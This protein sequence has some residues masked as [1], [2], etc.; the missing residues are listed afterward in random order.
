MPVTFIQ[1]TRFDVAFSPTSIS[2][3]RAWYDAA[4]TA[5]ITSTGGYVTQWNDKSS[6]AYHATAAG[7]DRPQTGIN[8]INGR[9]VLT[10]DTNKLTIPTAFTFG[11]GQ[12]MTTYAVVMKNAVTN[13]TCILN[14]SDGVGPFFALTA[15]ATSGA[16]YSRRNNGSGITYA[17]ANVPNNNWCIIHVAD[18][19]GTTS[20]WTM[21]FN[22]TNEATSDATGTGQWKYIGSYDYS[23]GYSLKGRIAEILIYDS[24]LSAGND[25]AV[26]SYLRTKWGT[27][28]M[29]GGTITAPGDGYV[30]HAF[31]SNGT[32]TP[33]G[34][35]V[36]V[37]YLVVGGGGGGSN[38][39]AGGGGAG[40]FLTGNVSIASAQV[41]T[42]GNGGPVNTNGSDSSI[43][44][45]VVATG[46]GKGGEAGQVGSGGGSGGG[47]GS[48]GATGGTSTSGQGHDGGRGDTVHINGRGGGG[49][50]AG[51]AGISGNV[52]VPHG[53][54][55]L[56]STIS[57]A[58]VTY[59][60][61]GGGGAD[62]TSGT[63]VPGDGGSGGGGQGA[64][65]GRNVT[66]G[67]ANSGG[68]GGGGNGIFGVSGGG[69][70][71]GGSGIVIVRYPVD[72]VQT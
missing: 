15:D 44:A 50:G 60:G 47:A 54:D 51:T 65:P 19:G 18:T 28:L 24:V 27:P 21:G 8:T 30:H 16:P 22:G 26:L 5:T 39:R 29:T 3:C 2:G 23:T 10:F 31:T 63:A 43:G 49:G 6:Y 61:G 41:I 56:T 68:G 33:I 34:G 57:G 67:T 59:A 7:A 69:G 20:A 32:L 53:G 64:G 42:V 70:A 37:E 17:T 36:E 35:P 4:D 62:A 52:G 45:L 9:N 14:G 25:A 38:N 40:G 11:D 55:G 13:G 12:A 71:A 72:Y 1:P 66:A 58:S 48:V 46:G